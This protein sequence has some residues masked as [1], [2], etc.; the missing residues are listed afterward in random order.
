MYSSKCRSGAP[1]SRQ[2]FPACSHAAVVEIERSYISAPT[3]CVLR[4][5]HHAVEHTTPRPRQ[6][7]SLAGAKT[8]R[9]YANTPQFYCGTQSRRLRARLRQPPRHDGA[10]RRFLQAVTSDNRRHVQRQARVRQGAEGLDNVRRATNGRLANTQTHTNAH[11]MTAS[12]RSH[13]RTHT[14]HIRA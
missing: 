7:M 11:P 13:Q 8:R 3:H 6:H 14:Q 9:T 1:I 4:Q 2:Q 5:P 10:S 12:R